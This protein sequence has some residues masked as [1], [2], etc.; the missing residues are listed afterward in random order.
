MKTES[1][2]NLMDVRGESQSAQAQDARKRY[3]REVNALARKVDQ[4]RVDSQRFF[5][6]DLRLPPDDLK[7]EIKDA[8]R[9]LQSSKLATSSL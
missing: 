4:L 3:E 9:R 5:A 1:Q 6:G 8:L 7:D 2:K